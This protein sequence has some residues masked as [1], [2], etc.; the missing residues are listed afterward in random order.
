MSRIWLA[1]AVLLALAGWL[2]TGSPVLAA[3]AA[4]D[5]LNILKAIIRDLVDVRRIGLRALKAYSTVN[6]HKDADHMDYGEWI[7]RLRYEMRGGFA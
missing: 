6:L 7:C 4:L 5:T 1:A 2:L 3:P